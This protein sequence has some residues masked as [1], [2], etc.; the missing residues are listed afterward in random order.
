MLQVANA[1]PVSGHLCFTRT[2]EKRSVLVAGIVD[3]SKFSQPNPH[4]TAKPI[5]Q[6][7]K[8]RSKHH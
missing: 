4:I 2:L 3:I 7:R 8:W 5:T 6:Q 1:L